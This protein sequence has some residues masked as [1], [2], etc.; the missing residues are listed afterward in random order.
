MNV[1][2]NFQ[3]LIAARQESHGGLMGVWEMMAMD[4]FE[5]SMQE[6][7]SLENSDT[8]KTLLLEMDCRAKFEPVPP[9]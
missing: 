1:F 7:T 4:L 5:C 9:C 3:V 8:T 6:G 2:L